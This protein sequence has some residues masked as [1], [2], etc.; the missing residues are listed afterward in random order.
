MK[1]YLIYRVPYLKLPCGLF[2]CHLLF[3]K[4]A[5][6]CYV[7][8]KLCGP[9]WLIIYQTHMIWPT[10]NIKPGLRGFISRSRLI[11][12]QMAMESERKNTQLELQTCFASAEQETL[13]KNGSVDKTPHEL[14]RIWIPGKKYKTLRLSPEFSNY[15][16]QTGI[17]IFWGSDAIRP[18]RR[19]WRSDWVKS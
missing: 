4:I 13:T 18:W 7:K 12:F 3:R 16:S 1:I 6:T 2:V 14:S 11:R 8:I 17:A 5:W 15:E 9:I 19:Y 10:L